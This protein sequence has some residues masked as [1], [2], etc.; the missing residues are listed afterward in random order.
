MSRNP[1]RR[2]VGPSEVVDSLSVILIKRP[3]TAIQFQAD[4]PELE[5]EGISSVD[6]VNL[7]DIHCAAEARSIHDVLD[8]VFS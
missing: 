3:K 8:M 1:V 4:I 6:D 5:A 2:G 7:S